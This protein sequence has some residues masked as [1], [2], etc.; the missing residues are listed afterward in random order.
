MTD[1]V[2]VGAG[3]IGMLTAHELVSAGM[4]VCMLERGQPARE[5]SWA[6]GGILSPLYPWRYPDAVSELAR[7][8][9]HYY[10]ELC[11]QCAAGSGIDP[12]WTRSG[13]LI[14][15]IDDPAQV[16]QWATRFGARL[17]QLDTAGIREL[18]PELGLHPGSAAWLPEVAQIRNP[19]LVKSL[20]A[21]LEQ[22]GVE[23]RP[24]C[25]A[26]GWDIEGG[27]VRSVRT[28]GGAV[29]ADAFIVASGAWTGPLLESTGLSLPIE[30]VRGQMLLF[31]GEPGLV[32]CISLHKGRYVI[33]RRD[34][35]VLVGSTLEYV[36]FDKQT[37]AQARDELHRS[38]LQLIPALASLKI[39]KHWA[40]LRPGSPDGT[41]VIGPHP[42]IANLYINAGHFR[43]GVVLGPASARLLAD[44][45]LKR[46]PTLDIAPYQVENIKNINLS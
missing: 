31:Q 40:G 38:A 6:G 43:N 2:I 18:A 7:W 42:D 27:R 29:S 26:Q 44:Q 3:L 32:S 4:Q 12:Q 30:P 24:D 1:V 39:E 33:P 35:R 41:P 16:Q 5:S 21:M 15:D 19:R 22:R 25:P 17:E 46:A 14:T 37:T 10:P 8:S 20:R 36:G 34:G 13:L 11:R 23:I 9:Q 45:L 28:P